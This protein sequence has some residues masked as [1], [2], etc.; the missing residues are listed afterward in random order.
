MN[1]ELVK[2]FTAITV[3][4]SAINASI[5]KE[6]AF[7]SAGLNSALETAYEASAA[8]NL[9]INAPL[10]YR[11]LYES[12]LSKFADELYESAKRENGEAQYY[13]DKVILTCA[14]VLLTDHEALESK[15]TLFDMELKRRCSGFSSPKLQS[16]INA[17][18]WIENARDNGYF[19]AK[20]LFF[21]K[22][23]DL[24]E[25]ELIALIE[26][27]IR[28]KHP[29]A[30]HII[31]IMSTSSVHEKAWNLLSC[32]Y[33]HHCERRFDSNS[34]FFK[35]WHSKASK[36]CTLREDNICDPNNLKYVD[37]LALTLPTEVFKDVVQTKIEFQHAIENGDI[38]SLSAMVKNY[39]EPL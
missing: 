29:D 12:K 3:V 4:I 1:L 21:D 6:Q 5:A 24:N 25:K 8:H 17:G 9:F 19:L 22:R 32:D 23:P 34:I 2:L 11:F 33:G 18:R 10:E 16:L 30:F 13:L 27:G 28:S 26:E 37:Y 36:A 14:S 7:D 35:T 39:V 15:L 31:S 20:M 38:A